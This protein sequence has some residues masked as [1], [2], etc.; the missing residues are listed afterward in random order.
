[1]SD[2]EVVP[3]YELNLDDLPKIDGHNWER[4]GLKVSCDGC[5]THPYHEHFIK[6]NQRKA[7]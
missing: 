5:G 6:E 1:M 2:E 7:V 4:R 3:D